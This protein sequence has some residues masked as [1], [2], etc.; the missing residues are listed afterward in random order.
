[1]SVRR[2]KIA[3]FRRKHNSHPQRYPR[4][5]PTTPHFLE[6]VPVVLRPGLP[7]RGQQRTIWRTG[8]HWS[9]RIQ[10]VDCSERYP[11]AIFMVQ[12]ARPLPLPRSEPWLRFSVALPLGTNGA[13]RHSKTGRVY[14]NRQPLPQITGSL[15]PKPLP[16]PRKNDPKIWQ[17]RK[18]KSIFVTAMVRHS[19]PSRPRDPGRR[20]SKGN[21]VRIPDSPAAVSPS[22]LPWQRR[23]AGRP[24]FLCTPLSASGFSVRRIGRHSGWEGA[25]GRP[26]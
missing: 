13:A 17:V 19:P 21:R 25:V 12:H 22:A 3:R 24:T 23:H 4:L 5:R 11:R 8:W 18:K 16:A 7:R 1:M 6:S 10:L 20:R 9:S 26:G 14:P 2:T 15:Y